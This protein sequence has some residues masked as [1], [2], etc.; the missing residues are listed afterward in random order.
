MA[1]LYRT[2]ALLG[3]SATLAALPAAAEVLVIR[4][5]DVDDDC[6]ARD[7]I[8]ALGT[9]EFVRE[10]GM[11]FEMDIAC[12]TLDGPVDEAAVQ[13]AMAKTEFS[14]LE[15]RREPACP[16]GTAP[17]IDPWKDTAGLDAAIVSRGEV[18]D[19]P[20]A[21]AAA[22]YTVF[23]FGAPW[24][25]PCIGAAE[26]LKGELRAHPDLA[27]RAITLEGATP[28]ESFAQPVVAQHMA[29]AEGVPWFVVLDPAGKTL[30]QGSDLDA[31]LK[32]IA[33]KARWKAQPA[34]A[35]AP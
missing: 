9:L 25:G 2:L 18:F 4:T 7:V 28:Q 24:C 34:P 3:W 5:S 26:R 30:Y 31:A 22:K 21:R 19:L 33:K 32:K 6:C 13:A 10:V 11:S 14:V 8:A 35:A 17:R 15:I 27:V 23:D 20:A 16:Q 1:L 29:W 12:A